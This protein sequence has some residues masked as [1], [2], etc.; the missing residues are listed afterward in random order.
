MRLSYMKESE[1]DTT[2]IIHIVKRPAD[3]WQFMNDILAT[4][5]EFSY[6]A[7][8]EYRE[9]FKQNHKKS[10]MPKLCEICDKFFKIAESYRLDQN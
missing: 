1:K 6:R 9:P 8:R 7:K 2:I 4:T 3:G 5:H 10:K